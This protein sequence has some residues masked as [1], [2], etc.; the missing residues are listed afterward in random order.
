MGLR[1]PKRIQEKSAWSDG[2]NLILGPLKAEHTR[3]SSENRW[4]NYKR[5]VYICGNDLCN[6]QRQLAIGTLV[7]VRNIESCPE[8]MLN[9]AVDT[10]RSS[11]SCHQSRWFY[12][13]DSRFLLFLFFSWLSPLFYG[14][15]NVRMKKW[16]AEILKVC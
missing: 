4:E 15:E 7:L 14:K 6:N 9:C 11:H 2:V 10:P 3:E 16:K 5:P 12:P 1:T 13:P 8:A